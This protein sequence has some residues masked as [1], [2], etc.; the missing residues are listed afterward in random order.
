MTTPVP[1]LLSPSSPTAHR[2]EVSGEQGDYREIRR[3]VERAGLLAS[4]PGY[5][6]QKLLVTGGLLVGG[7]AFLTVFHALWAVI[8]GALFFS[9]VSVQVAFIVHDAGHRQGF[10]RRWQNTLV[11]LIGANVL[12]GASYGWWVRKHNAHHAHPNHLDMDPDI[13]LPLI[14][15][16]PAQALE[17]R[18]PARFVVKHQLLFAVPLL[19]LV[20]YGQRIGSVLFLLRGRTRHRRWEVAALILNAVLYVGLSLALLGPLRALL[21]IVIHQGCTG[22]YLGL[23]FAPNHKGMT[24]VD[25]DTP[26]DSLRAQVMTARNVRGN[27]V[28]D[29][30]YG[31]LNY[32]VEHHLFPALARNRLGAAQRIVAAFCRERDIPYHETSVL[33][34]YTEILASLRVAAAPLQEYRREGRG[35]HGFV[36]AREAPRSRAVRPR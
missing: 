10:V 31:G 15:F 28:T 5:F 14:A 24:M 6:G 16:T 18:G 11:G 23:V 32:Q 7:L 25:G 33:R 4:Q 1:A 30:C 29:W 27:P 20:A 9:V 8:I 26:L 36:T 34:S 21:F 22:L 12:L 17:K 19:T 2:A 3:R 13:D 35:A